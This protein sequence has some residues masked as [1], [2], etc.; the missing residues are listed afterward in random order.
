[1]LSFWHC[2]CPFSHPLWRQTLLHANQCNEDS[3]TWTHCYL[4]SI[5]HTL[6]FP[7]LILIVSE[8]PWQEPP[9]I[10][11]LLAVRHPGVSW[12]PQD[13]FTWRA[14]PVLWPRIHFPVSWDQS[15][16]LCTRKKPLFPLQK[17][18][19]L[20]SVSRPKKHIPEKETKERNQHHL[21]SHFPTKPAFQKG[22]PLDSV[23]K[24]HFH[25]QLKTLAL[26][27]NSSMTSSSPRLVHS[28]IST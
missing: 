25:V 24:C 18:L 3:S 17:L 8:L 11:P 15:F 10:E 28:F 19:K 12:Q 27:P 14:P 13:W 26:G 1:M 2:Q 7:P 21:P 5:Q 20:S 4:A 23:W 9:P 22:L 6:I 16:P